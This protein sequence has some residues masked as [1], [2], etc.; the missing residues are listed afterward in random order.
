MFWLKAFSAKIVKEGAFTLARM[1]EVWMAP[2]T[3]KRKGR[4]LY[5]SA[6]PTNEAARVPIASG[7]TL[8]H[9]K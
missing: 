3:T 1:A 5:A 7:I 9:A 6:L 2:I 8:D 4:L